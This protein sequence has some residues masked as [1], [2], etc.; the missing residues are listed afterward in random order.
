MIQRY[1]L[2]ILCA[3]NIHKSERCLLNSQIH[4]GQP[5]P[6]IIRD[7]RL[8]EPTDRAGN[9]ALESG[10][11]LTLSC[12]GVGSIYH[13]NKIRDEGTATITCGGGENFYN[14]H[15][16]SALSPF[17]S[18]RCASPPN[19]VSRR[20]NRTC[21]EGNPIF[22]VGYSVQGNFY[23]VYESCFNERTLNA[24]YSK[25]TQR[26]YNANFQ[27][28]VDRPYFV[29]N[30]VYG[31]APVETLFS[32]RG[33]KEA[34]R[35]LVGS[36]VNEYITEKELLSRGH[37]AAKTDFVFAFGERATFHYVNC[38]PQWYGFNS[39]N[40]NTLEVD[41]RR[42]IHNADVDTVIY[43]G[44]YEVTQLFTEYGARVDIY[45]YSDQNNNPVIPVPLYFYKVVY[46]PATNRGI[47]FVGIN[48]PY[49]SRSDAEDLFFCENICNK[50]SEFH[51]LS[52]HPHNAREGYTFC[53]SV[54][55]FRNT[56]THLP[57]FE[58]TSIFR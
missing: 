46:E 4:F 14:T 2:L 56:I 42:Y 20:T 11:T 7:G 28:R 6:I 57:S 32:P 58:V 38:A 33:Q 35:G 47:A 25:Y 29:A 18:F 52:W 54:P 51:W 22:Q 30:D 23:D 9:V 44:T 48:G 43:T 55:D 5:L 16:L 3:L 53:C 12:E 39:G 19:Y 40:W 10:E 31:S 15:W 50:S 36:M 49:Y 41:L 21:F 24:V 37:L 34:V 17:S 45:L 8:L 27:T 13:P 26:P 1:L